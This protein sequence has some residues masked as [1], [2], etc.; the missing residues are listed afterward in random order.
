MDYIPVVFDPQSTKPLY[1]QIYACLAEQIAS[2]QLTAGQRLPARRSAAANLGVSRNTV[3]TAYAMLEEEG[4]IETKPRSGYFV[5]DIAPLFPF[6][7]Q[8][9]TAALPAFEPQESTFRVQFSTRG[10]DAGLFPAKT[11]ARIE[12]GQLARLETLLQPGQAQGDLQLRQAIAAYLS[13]YRAVRCTPDQ[14]IV[15]AGIE[16]LLGLLAQLLREKK[17]AVEDPGYQKTGVILQNSQ[18]VTVPVPVDAGGIQLDKLYESGAQVAYV[19]PSHQFPT[20][21]F[22]PMGRRSALLA[23]AAADLDRLIVEDDYDSEFRFS[24]RATPS[25]QGL[26]STGQVV[27]LGTFSQSLAPSIRIGYMVLPP[28]IL[29]AWRQRFAGYASTVSRFE[30]QTLAELLSGGHFARHL[31]R[32][33]GVY[34]RR[35]DALVSALQH[36]FGS[37]VEFGGLHTGL[38]LTATLKLG[39]SE[40]QLCQ[41]A[42]NAGVLVT[43]LSRYQRLAASPNFPVLVL[44][45]GALETQQIT[46]AVGLLKKAWLNPG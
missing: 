20:G 39:L 17:V 1:Y 37:Q 42:E 46:H 11:W 8:G 34:R 23:W 9:S 32:A 28:H 2:G 12:R 38:F 19:T 26:C 6:Q 29:A 15:G 18:V 41:R 16:Y 13:Q 4:Y 25:L 31:N 30:Q 44:G 33:R 35:R 7:P 3:E 40:S 43:G 5:A 22:M 27:Y 24:G 36:A 45:Y 21:A 14:I 10:M